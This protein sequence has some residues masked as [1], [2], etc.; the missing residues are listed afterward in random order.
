MK[1]FGLVL[2]T[3]VLV[4]ATVNIELEKRSLLNNRLELKIPK[5]FQIMSEEMLNTKYPSANRPKMV[6]TNKTGGI[7][8]ALNLTE[9]QAS[10]SQIDSYKDYLVQ[11]FE[12]VYPSAEWKSSGVTTINGRKIGYL[13]LV[14]PAID[15]EIYNLIFF[16]DLD[17][18]LLLC[19]F[20]CT[21]DSMNEWSPA[22]KEIMHSLRVK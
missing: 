14:T 1:Y 12:S 6:Y 21:V 18:K 19:T 11:T 3:L 8:V 9:S 16:T 22:A 17:G 15:A 2:L 13:E 5:D 7:N 10:Q 4:S 20:N